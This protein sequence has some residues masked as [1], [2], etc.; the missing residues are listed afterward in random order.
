MESFLFLGYS[1]DAWITIVTV[2]GMFAILLFTK[3]RTDVVFLGAIGLLY[4][5]G[6]LDSKE[7]FSGFS[8]TSV[9]VVGVLF[10]VVAGLNHT[11]VLQWIVKN[12]LG[13]PKSY[14][15]A[16]L[17][18][19]LP[20]AFLSSFLSNTTVVAMFVKI[21]KLWSKKLNLSP[22]KLLI[23]LSYAS[24]MGGVCT[25]IGTPPNLIISGLYESK[26]GISMNVFTTALPGLFCLIVGITAIIL[27]RRLLPNR[28]ASDKAFANT[29]NYT[30]EF[31]VPSNHINIGKTV[32]ELGL[33]KVR[34]GSLIELIHFDNNKFMSPVPAD[35]PIM[36]AD[37][38]VFAG[39]VDK[40]L[41]LKKQF[42]F[43]TADHAIF[44]TSE[45][46]SKRKLRT[47]FVTF[48][49]PLIGKSIGS[50]SFEHDYG[51]VLVAVSRSG[52]RIN[53]S[54]HEV[55]LEAGDT[56]LLECGVHMEPNL[57]SL[58]TLLDFFD[59]EDIPNTGIPTLISTAIMI[60]MVALSAF[61]VMPLL[62]CAILAAVA[63]LI[64]QCCSPQQAMRA[65]NWEIIMVFAGSVVLGL[66]IQKT[67]IA[68]NIAY[69]I[70]NTCGNNPIVVMAAI[71]FVGTFVTEFISNTA[72]GAMFFPIMWEAA[73]KLGY[74]PF[75]FL[76]ALMI[77]VSSSFAT[78]IGSPTHMLVYGPG[79]Y[80]F[81]DFMRIGLLMNIIILA[82][83]ILI[84]NIIYP[85]TPLQ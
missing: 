67:G 36:G 55:K 11:G 38:L 80:R 70:L 4:I 66:A 30:I 85:L 72:A 45:I 32:E 53:E 8:S 75:P 68:E 71:C 76:I 10:V 79:G 39:Q 44:S 14:I 3:L 43:V 61:G 69:S 34:G 2:I 19:M 22:S 64:C 33:Q 50:S 73:T 41:E 59:S 82:A 56:L 13:E 15:V 12:L 48:G 18:L 28:Q 81:S 52:K 74:E 7:A 5:T 35:E 29:N 26:T 27:M 77:S 17:R 49:S 84:V 42:G 58:N 51:M 25:L 63:M 21:V 46:D 37:R 65:I 54:P 24:G 62:Q 83:N 60:A 47:A 20:V 78:P 57:P 31:L 40:L 16:V 1:L 23:P 6:V 9:V